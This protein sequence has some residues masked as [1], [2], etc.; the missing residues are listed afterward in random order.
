MFNYTKALT[1]ILLVS[2]GISTNATEYWVSQMGNDDSDCK[3]L[4][5]A[6]KTIQKGISILVAGDILNIDEGTYIEDSATSLHSDK[7]GL[8]DANYGSLCVLSSGT[9]SQPIVIRAL[10]GKEK[11]VIIDSE[12]KR[13]GLIIRKQDYIHVKNLTFI[14]SW[15][16]G[17]ATPGGPAGVPDESQLSIGCLIEGN[18]I[19]K[20]TGAKGVNNSAIYMWSTKDWIVRGNTVNYVY[21][22]GTASNGIQT[23]GTINAIIENNTITEVDHGINWKDHYVTSDGQLFQESIIRNNFFSVTSAGIRISIRADG[24]N[25]A[26]HN[27]IEGNIIELENSSAI[28]IAAYL[29]GANAISG[30]FDIKHNLFISRTGGNKGIEADS[31]N[32]ITVVGNVFAGIKVPMSLRLKQ[33]TRPAALVKSDYNVFDTTFQIQHDSNHTDEENYDTL[34]NWQAVQPSKDETLFSLQYDF[35]D[36]YS[37]QQSGVKIL[38]ANIDDY[39]DVI[40]EVLIDNGKSYQPGPYQKNDQVIG[41]GELKPKAPSDARMKIL[42]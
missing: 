10:P 5:S 7:C 15:T 9:P 4:S 31:L 23:Y 27:Q 1:L 32:S 11:K 3:S 14:N 8:L 6:C 17:I 25:P 28:G 29:A 40:P 38:E 33:V 30:D 16:G 21:G 34:K 39:K 37:I 2:T 35:P 19:L 22:N 24:S 13:A 42:N 26:G 36:R 12:G 20:T 18:T 41:S